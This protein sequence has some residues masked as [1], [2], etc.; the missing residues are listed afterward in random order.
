M[1]E[2]ALLVMIFFY[3]AS[4]MLL[5]VQFMLG[6]IYGKDMVNWKGDIMRS[7]VLDYLDEDNFNSKTQAA[8]DA[9]KTSTLLD[10]FIGAATIGWDFFLFLS[11]TYIFTLLVFFGIPEIIVA[12]IVATY[13]VLLVRALIGLIRGS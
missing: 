11:G 2:K 4:F 5:G 12:A 1:R 10:T 9:D 7:S 13:L 8:L 6:D 3:L